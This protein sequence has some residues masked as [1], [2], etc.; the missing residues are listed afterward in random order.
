MESLGLLSPSFFLGTIACYTSGGGQGLVQMAAALPQR[1]RKARRRPTNPADLQSRQRKRDSRPRFIFHRCLVR[2][3]TSR[4]IPCKLYT[5]DAPPFKV[6]ACR[7][8]VASFWEGQSICVARAERSTSTSFFFLQL[9]SRR[10]PAL[11]FF[12]PDCAT[13]SSS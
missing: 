2:S 3:L 13:Y 11:W 12:S 5:A 1:C 7:S 6:S 4:I 9:S 10:S 8:G